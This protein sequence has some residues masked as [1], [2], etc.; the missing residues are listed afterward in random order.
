MKST[1]KQ[2]A[3]K[4]KDRQYHCEKRNG[5]IIVRAEM[6]ACGQKIIAG[7]YN[8]AQ[9]LWESGKYK[10]PLPKEVKQAIEEIYISS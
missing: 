4:H 5:K 1:P 3:I 10:A 6:T 8:L 9:N 2:R 7:I